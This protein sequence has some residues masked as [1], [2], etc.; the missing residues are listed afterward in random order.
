MNSLLIVSIIVLYFAVLLVTSYIT[1]KK[2]SDN[3]AFFI[4]NRQS[5]WY[6][7]AIGMIGASISGVTF[8]SVPGWVRSTDM[9]YIQMALGFFFG[10]M[11]IAH[12]LLPLYYKLNLT[13]IYTYLQTRM[14]VRAYKTG[15]SFFLLSKLLG[16][17]ARLYIVVMIMQ[18]YIFDTWGVPFY[19]SVTV[20]VALI[21]LYTFRSGIRTIIWTDLLQTFFLLAALILII[22][23]VISQ[24]DFSFSETVSAITTN[25]HFR[26]F[27]FDIKSPQNFFKQFISGIFVV[28]AMTG[29]DQDMMQKNISCRNLKEAQKNIYGYAW[30]FVPIN[31][32]FLCLGILLLIFAQ[33][34]QIEL[35]AVSDQILPSFAA[36]GTLGTAVVVF[37]MIGLMS[38]AFSSADS[39]LTSLTTSFCVDILETSKRKPEIAKSIRLKTHI[40]ISIIFILTILIF[41]IANNTSIINAIYIM[42]SYTYGPLIGMF[43][44]GL[45]TKIRPNDKWIPAICI[46]S[47][48]LSF[49]FDMLIFKFTGYKCGYELLIING[50]ITFIGLWI[51]G[52]IAR[53]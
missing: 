23:Q 3:E 13:S 11:F 14:G 6:V 1:G 48:G 45:F 30:T 25:E 12:V 44:F 7:V 35:P 18:H 46:L 29:L 31:F 37:F 39:A 19:V 41:R 10:Y 47:P 27:E 8:V 9:T 43:A 26:I 15:A 5:P 4:G 24:L 22:W 38:A 51:S 21:F 32:L 2:H 36:T 42:V 20:I 53:K 34:H 17:A 49:L 16:A 50:L 40:Y 33:T 28:I 52:N